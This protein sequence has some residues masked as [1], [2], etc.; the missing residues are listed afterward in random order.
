[1]AIEWQSAFDRRWL[2][3]GEGARPQTRG[4]EAA[5]GFRISLGIVETDW[6]KNIKSKNA[7]VYRFVAISESEGGCLRG[8]DKSLIWGA[9]A[10][11]R[12]YARA[13]FLRNAFRRPDAR[14]RNPDLVPD[15]LLFSG[16][17]R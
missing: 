12:I 15:V 11:A 9:R 10:D 8:E 17:H 3:R 2:R 1:M 16:F 5:G 6:P 14:L 13:L 4:V 7:T